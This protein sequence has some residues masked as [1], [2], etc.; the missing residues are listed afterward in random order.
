MIYD[1]IILIFEGIDNF[2]D[3]LDLHR[4][5]N[6]SFWLPKYFPKNIKVIVTAEKNSNSMRILKS[7]CQVIPIVCDQKIIKQIVNH[8][9]TRHVLLP[10]ENS[11]Y[12]RDLFI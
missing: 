8:H 10:E 7:T 6:V 2:K 5:A 11:L 9:F 1:K 4:E 12:L 3:M